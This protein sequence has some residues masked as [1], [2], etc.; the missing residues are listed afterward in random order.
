[1]RAAPGTGKYD[2]TTVLEVVSANPARHAIT[3][4]DLIDGPR[5]RFVTDAIVSVPTTATFEGVK[6]VVNLAQLDLF[7]AYD[8]ATLG[9][10]MRTYM[11]GRL[12]RNKG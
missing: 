11:A 10:E 2:G 8:I 12:P 7:C 4:V 3:R 5:L 6:T 1:M 9:Y